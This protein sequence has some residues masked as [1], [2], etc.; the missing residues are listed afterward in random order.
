MSSL[1]D[2]NTP[3]ILIIGIVF[4]GLITTAVFKKLKR[5]ITYR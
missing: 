1:S 4:S 3:L 5:V 2:L